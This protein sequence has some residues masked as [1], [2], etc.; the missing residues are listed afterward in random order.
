MKY[1]KLLVF[2]AIIC[3]AGFSAIAQK[4]PSASKKF[5]PYKVPKLRTLIG[6]YSDSLS[7]TAEEAE[8]IVGLP[9]RIVDDKKNAYAVNSY[10][11]LYKKRVVTENEE[12]GKVSPTTS[13]ASSRFQA[14]P[15]PA[16]WINQVKE[17]LKKGE[18]IQFFDI[19]VKDPQGRI[20][21]APA[22][23]ITII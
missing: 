12:T 11:F 15:L 16:L 4:Q 10:Q 8:K 20:M 3:T 9:L 17:Q 18:E 14:S 21:Y 1:I 19:I 23:K 22:L 5:P 13:I 2:T 6:Q 7:L